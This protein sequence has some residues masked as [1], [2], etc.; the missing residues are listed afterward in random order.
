MN[1]FIDISF[2]RHETGYQKHPFA[3]G[4]IRVETLIKGNC[5][6]YFKKDVSSILVSFQIRFFYLMN[7]SFKLGGFRKTYF[8]SNSFVSN[9]GVS[10]TI[11]K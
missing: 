9:Y 3:A 11:L 10:L 8:L 4:K 5:M 7:I 6:Q 2:E 1:S